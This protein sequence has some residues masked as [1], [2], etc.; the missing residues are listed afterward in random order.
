MPVIDLE[1][2]E[3]LDEVTLEYHAY[4]D[5]HEAKQ[6][7]WEHDEKQRRLAIQIVLG[8]LLRRPSKIIWED[9]YYTSGWRGFLYKAKTLICLLAERQGCRDYRDPDLCAIAHGSCY[10]GWWS[11][12]LS[13][14][15]GL[16]RWFYDIYDDGETN[17]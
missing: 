10:G 6:E 12:Q 4:M 1:K 11:E 5:S 7:A 9:A 13:V 15:R 14:G 3:M 16:G 2:V 17:L 8:S